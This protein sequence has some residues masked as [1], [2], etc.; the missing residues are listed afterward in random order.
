M[1]RLEE[2]CSILEVIE[3]DISEEIFFIEVCE[4]SLYNF[5]GGVLR[6][7]TLIKE[8]D[9]IGELLRLMFEYCFRDFL[10]IIYL[11][12]RISFRTASLKIIKIFLRL[13]CGIGIFEFG[14]FEYCVSVLG[15]FSYIVFSSFILRDLF[16]LKRIRYI[17]KS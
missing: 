1:M 15:V 6:C 2:L 14:G 4:G 3:V 9:G 8:S 13:S 5:L 11:F 16:V 17:R 7:Y 10:K 12:K